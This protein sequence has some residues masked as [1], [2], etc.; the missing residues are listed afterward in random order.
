MRYQTPVKHNQFP[1]YI[2]PRVVRGVKGG[3]TFT[4]CLFGEVA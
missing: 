3:N 1:R 4:H 2:I